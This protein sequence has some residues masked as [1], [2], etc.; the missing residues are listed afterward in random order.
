MK[1]NLLF[2]FLIS[3]VFAKENDALKRLEF[4]CVIKASKIEAISMKKNKDIELGKAY[5]K[6]LN[7]CQ[8]EID[9]NV[10]SMYYKTDKLGGFDSF[11]KVYTETVLRDKIIFYT[12][13]QWGFLTKCK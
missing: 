1:K 9:D 6:V 8:K 12:G 3:T 2:M 10:K 11:K 13:V 4:D 7:S 5:K